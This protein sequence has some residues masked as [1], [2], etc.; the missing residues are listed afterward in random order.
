MPRS[1]TLIFK[2]TTD[3]RMGGT[4]EKLE[5]MDYKLNELF[6]DIQGIELKSSDIYKL[7]GSSDYDTIQWRKEYSIRKTTNKLTWN[8]IYKIVNKVQAT[9]YRFV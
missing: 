8:D 1:R 6:S 3:E 9:R 5:L 2:F 7:G 4:R